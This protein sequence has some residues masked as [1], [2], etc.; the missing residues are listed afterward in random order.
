[1]TP[2]AR[3]VAAGL[4]AGVLMLLLL[5]SGL[6]N[7]PSPAPKA[8][9]K[10]TDGT[11][12]S[13]APAPEDNPLREAEAQLRSLLERAQEGDV[14]G[15]LSAFAQP[16]RA[17]IEREADERGRERFAADLREASKSRKSHA[18]FAPQADGPDACLIT[19]ESVYPDRNERQTYRLEQTGA[20]WL[21][22]SVDNAK[23]REPTA[24]YGTPAAYLAPE[25]VPVQASDVVPAEEQ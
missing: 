3:K 19:V 12:S 5:L 18:V 6:R 17:R 10:A 13:S 24:R 21:V 14:S 2:L 11:S 16:L 20:G 7:G 1:M 4:V 15:Y 23:A 9:D 8:S 25:G 22:S